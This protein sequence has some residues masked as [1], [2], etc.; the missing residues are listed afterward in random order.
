MTV[1]DVGRELEDL[2]KLLQSRA[3]REPF[4]FFLSMPSDRLPY[5]R[6][7]IDMKL[8]AL[9]STFEQDV[10]GDEEFLGLIADLVEYRIALFHS[11]I[12]FAPV[13]GTKGP[14]TKDAS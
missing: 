13:P 4:T 12:P 6:S 5:L 7:R 2:R 11:P 14:L 8:A 9:G 10:L 1:D 3:Q